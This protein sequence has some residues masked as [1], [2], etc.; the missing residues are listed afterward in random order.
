LLGRSGAV[1]IKPPHNKRTS[2]AERNSN[3]RC[4]AAERYWDAVAWAI[5][6]YTWRF[7]ALISPPDAPAENTR[8]L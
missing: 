4:L 2:S 1:P 5:E 3:A 8:G 7:E 6:E